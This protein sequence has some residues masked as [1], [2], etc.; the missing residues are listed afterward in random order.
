MYRRGRRVELLAGFDSPPLLLLQLHHPDVAVTVTEGKQCR[1]QSTRGALKQR[2]AVSHRVRGASR[3]H[4]PNRIRVPKAAVAETIRRIRLHPRS[5]RRRQAIPRVPLLSRRPT[6]YPRPH[7]PLRRQG[8]ICF[9]HLSLL[10]RQLPSPPHLLSRGRPLRRFPSNQKRRSG[11]RFPDADLP[12]V[13][14]LCCLP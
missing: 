6:Y 8:L 3:V 10:R 13:R 12:F 7:L 14:S 2:L 5:R 1:C 4:L 11:N 9:R